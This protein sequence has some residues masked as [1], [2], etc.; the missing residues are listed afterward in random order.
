M[1]DVVIKALDGRNSEFTVD[2]EIKVEDFKS[3]VEAKLSIPVAQQRLIFQGRVLQDG[4]RLIDHGVQNK[5]IHVVPRPPPSAHRDTSATSTGATE[6]GG[7][8]PGPTFPGFPLGGVEMQQAIHNITSM[9][10]SGVGEL[11]RSV[12]LQIPP[13]GGTGSHARLSSI[14]A[15]EET[16][17]RLYRQAVHLIRRMS[18]HPSSLQIDGTDE[19]NLS[20]PDDSSADSSN[21]ASPDADSITAGDSPK[22]SMPSGRSPTDKP[23]NPESPSVTISHSDVQT[24]GLPSDRDAQT[25]THPSETQSQPVASAST[26]PA[27]ERPI[28]ILADMLSRHRRLW[29]SVEPFLEQWETMLNNE[30]R[31]QE[32]NSEPATISK[33]RDSTVPETGNKPSAVVGDEDPSNQ[34]AEQTEAFSQSRENIVPNETGNESSHSWNQRFFLQVSRLLHLH[35]HMLHLISD[36]GVTPVLDTQSNPPVEA[37]STSHNTETTNIQN[38]SP[39]ASTTTEDASKQPEAPTKPPKKRP[40]PRRRLNVSDF[41]GH[42][43]RARINV[44]PVDPYSV[45]LGSDLM[46]PPT[47]VTERR[48]QVTAVDRRRSQSAS[49]AR[50]S[51]SANP[52]TNAASRIP[53]TFSSVNSSIPSGTLGSGGTAII[54]RFDIPIISMN[55]INL[56]TLIE[57]LTP[58][59]SSNTPSGESAVTAP[60]VNAARVAGA[61]DAQGATSTTGTNTV[62]TPTT[63]TSARHPQTASN[64]PTDP[65]LMCNSRHF[66][67]GHRRLSSPYGALNVPLPPGAHFS[68]VP[69]PPHPQQPRTTSSSAEASTAAREAS[70]TSTTSGGTA[71]TT[72]NPAFHFSSRMSFPQQLASFVSAATNAVVSAATNGFDGGRS[73]MNIF[74]SSSPIHFSVDSP[75]TMT[76]PMMASSRRATNNCC[77]A[78]STTGTTNTT[79]TAA[80]A[81]SAQGFSWVFGRENPLVSSVTMTSTLLQ[82]SQLNSDSQSSSTNRANVTRIDLPTPTWAQPPHSGQSS[83]ELSGVSRFISVFARALVDTVWYRLSQLALERGHQITASTQPY[84]NKSHPSGN[85]DRRV[86]VGFLTDILSAARM[87][88]LENPPSSTQSHSNQARTTASSLDQI[89]VHLRHLLSHADRVVSRGEDRGHLTDSLVEVAFDECVTDADVATSESTLEQCALAWVSGTIGSGN[90]VDDVRASLT[91]L[92]KTHLSSQLELWRTSPTNTGFGSTLLLTLGD[93]CIDFLCLSDLLVSQ[94]SSSSGLRQPSVPEDGA[95]AQ[96][97]VFGIADD[98]HYLSDQLQLFLQSLRDNQP[99]VQFG[100]V[101]VDGIERCIQRYLTMDAESIQKRRDHLDNTCRVSRTLPAVS[102]TERSAQQPVQ[103]EHCDADDTDMD[104]LP[105]VDASSEL[106]VL[107]STSKVG[108]SSSLNKLS[109]PH[110]H[111][112]H[113]KIIPDGPSPILSEHHPSERFGVATSGKISP[114]PEWNPQPD[115]LPDPLISALNPNSDSARFPVDAPDLPNPEGWHAVLPAEW[116]RVVAGDISTMANTEQSFSVNGES[117]HLE[118][119]SDAYIAGMPAKRRKVMEERARALAQTPDI[120]FTECLTDAIRTSGRGSTNQIRTNELKPMTIPSGTHTRSSH[121]SEGILVNGAEKETTNVSIPPKGLEMIVSLRE[122][123][124]ERIAARLS[125]DPDFDPVQ[126]PLSDEAFMKKDPQ[127]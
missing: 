17:N 3:L 88:L 68:V 76:A 25:A 33:P 99:D 47:I 18:R 107:N 16:F 42:M 19:A 78:A 37:V 12:H 85:H 70:T 114:L 89:R 24:A 55:M 10:L 120:L 43:I 118:R 54:H 26:P 119:F 71:G 62:T 101:L 46:P 126:F 60:A 84:A 91:R 50:R 113:R 51:G 90:E 40:C 100:R 66:G 35:A 98:F 2:D 117:Q 41:E 61:S 13:D 82:P 64:S 104:E 6:S 106:P 105:F 22:S 87:E 56:P 110:N 124:S 81:R 49:D 116:V 86:P 11:G 95:S 52:S 80:T 72:G 5:V 103:L 122:L 127:K 38:S 65:F 27:N 108:S 30:S 7:S 29:V 36:F 34:E 1:F 48:T 45:R 21:P 79:T 53:G 77:T 112:I 121:L 83:V 58:V 115:E 94:L 4:S 97:T 125:A 93:C 102:S 15:R 32:E 23:I 92:L 9:I 39:Q 96:L 111:A 67:D 75:S 123:V 28:S 74:V 44:E 57:R 31:I 20:A 14:A 73:P 69:P 63:A 109:L 8:V 59:T